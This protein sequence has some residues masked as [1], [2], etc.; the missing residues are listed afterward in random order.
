MDRSRKGQRVWDGVSLI[1][2]RRE[3]SHE[4]LIEK[5]LKLDGNNDWETLR[6]EINGY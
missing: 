6:R 2:K 1:N 3:W 5:N 4:K